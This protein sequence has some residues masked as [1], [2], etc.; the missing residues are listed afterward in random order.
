MVS[1]CNKW[2]QITRVHCC[3]SGMILV[4]AKN[5]AKKIQRP[6]I[7]SIIPKISL[8]SDPYFTLTIVILITSDAYFPGKVYLRPYPRLVFLTFSKKLKPKKTQGSNY[9]RKFQP[10][11]QRNGSNLNFRNSIFVNLCAQNLPI[12]SK[13]QKKTSQHTY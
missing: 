1:I 6:A 2:Q 8:S 3:D 9:S 5:I 4:F 7:F 11:T 13:L 10:K 12:F